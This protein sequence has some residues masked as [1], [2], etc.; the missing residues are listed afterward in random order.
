MLKQAV[1]FF[2]ENEENIAVFVADYNDVKQVLFI[3]GE[4]LERI[5]REFP[6][7]KG[8]LYVLMDGVIFKLEA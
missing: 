3:S 2:K 5:N 7:R 1:Y 8:N 6:K 4:R